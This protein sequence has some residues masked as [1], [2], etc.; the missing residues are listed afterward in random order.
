MVSAGS[1]S[2]RDRV[3]VLS[4]LHSLGPWAFLQNVCKVRW[5][6][7]LCSRS[8]NLLVH[9]LPGLRSWRQ[10]VQCGSDHMTHLLGPA[11]MV[12]AAHVSPWGMGSSAC[13]VSWSGSLNLTH[14]LS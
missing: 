4:V 2:S 13:Q 10:G 9:W 7:G 6:A 1:V 11:C 12:D 5:R 8:L 14:I 3:P